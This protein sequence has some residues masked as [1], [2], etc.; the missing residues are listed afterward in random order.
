MRCEFK[1]SNKNL[2]NAET[3]LIESP[4][5]SYKFPENYLVHHVAVLNY[6]QLMNLDAPVQADGMGTYFA[7]KVSNQNK[8]NRP[9]AYPASMNVKYFQAYDA[10]SVGEAISQ[11]VNK[12]FVTSF[13]EGANRALSPDYDQTPAAQE[14]AEALRADMAVVKSNVA[15]VTKAGF[16]HPQDV[17]LTRGL[18]H[19]NN[20][21][22]LLSDYRANRAEERLNNLSSY[23]MQR[24][25]DFVEWQKNAGP[26]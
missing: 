26:N 3:A 6:N 18:S 20:N 4:L 11:T 12:M 19:L 8:Q 10:T 13:I 9:L 21:P 15:S 2:V 16:Q 25:R 1:M 14:I 7:E 23:A 5:V 24:G 22:D 17:P